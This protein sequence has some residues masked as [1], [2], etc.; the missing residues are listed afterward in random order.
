[1][2][3]LSCL[4]P[5]VS[6]CAM[7]NVVATTYVVRVHTVLSTRTTIEKGSPLFKLQSLE[8]LERLADLSIKRAELVCENHGFKGPKRDGGAVAPVGTAPRIKIGAS[9]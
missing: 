4:E 9:N 8:I 1:M 3:I 5:T 7:I 6:S 2:E